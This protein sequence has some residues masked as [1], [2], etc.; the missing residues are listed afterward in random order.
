MQDKLIELLAPLKKHVVPGGYY[1]GNAGAHYPPRIAVMEAFSR[2]LWGIGPLVSG[3]GNCPNIDMV[4]SVLKEGTDPSSDGYWGEGGDKDQRLVETASIALTLMIAGKTFWEPLAPDEKKNLYRWLSVIEKR[5]LP[6]TNWH[7]FRIM[8]CAC[9]RELNLP[10]DEKEEKESFDL[11]ESLYRGD[12]WYEDGSGGNFDLYNPMGFHFYGLLWAKLAGEQN[13]E[14]AERYRERARLFGNRYSSWFAASGKAVPYGRSLTYRFGAASF[15]SA[16]AFADLPVLPWG[17]LKSLLLNNLRQW[18]SLPILDSGG[19]LSVGYAYPNL[20]MADRYNSPGSPYWGLK[21]WLVLA[22]GEDHPFWK[23]EETEGDKPGDDGRVAEKIITEKVPGF[24]ICKNSE[25]AQ[26]FTAGKFSPDFE[27]NHAAAK[28]GKF[29]YSARAGFCVS[30]GSYGL[31]ASGCD[32]SLVLS[33]GDNYW[34]ERRNVSNVRTGQTAVTGCANS[35]YGWVSSLW[36]PWPDVKVTTILVC[37]GA[38]HLRIHRIESGRFLHAAEGG[39]SVPRYREPWYQTGNDAA[40]T[41]PAD[42]NLTEALPVHNQGQEKQEALISFPWGASR[43]QALE[44]NS[45]RTGNILIPAPNLNVLFPHAAIP[46]LEGKIERGTT[47]LIS[48]VCRGDCPE[49]VNDLLPYVETRKDGS[50]VISP[51]RTTGADSSM[52]NFE[53]SFD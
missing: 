34:R 52:C 39:F 47:V 36:Q 19:L 45:E 33:E 16:C 18:F 9:F 44:A 46:I 7:F 2:T 11:I 43:I 17:T 13:P 20:V 29:V 50:F 21:A 8:V 42:K 27:M 48:A 12:G 3:G 26:L 1:L 53:V 31:E 6:P 38:W 51:K 4:L 10:V 23:T 41:N 30:I 24:V 40:E 35:N 32:S 25:D 5:E 22:L 37:L 15:F 14:R 28:Y 49:K